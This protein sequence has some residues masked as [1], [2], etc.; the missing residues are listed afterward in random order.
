MNPADC[1]CFN[2]R[3]TMRA[4]SRL[5]DASLAPLGLKN[6]QFSLLAVLDGIGP[7]TVSNLAEYMVMERTTL[8]RNL[9]PLERDGLLS[10]AAG[11]DRRQRVAKLTPAGRKLLAKA[12]PL[13]RPRRPKR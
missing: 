13:W 2:L 8:T 12:L 4:V 7:S 11:A 9:R 5:Y 1:L 3:K 6:T 10:L